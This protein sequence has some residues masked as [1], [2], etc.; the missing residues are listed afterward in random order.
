[1]ASRFFQIVAKSFPEILLPR[2]IRDQL[3]KMS[4]LSLHTATN[5]GMAQVEVIF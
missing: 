4:G 3:R 1:M 2:Q 5:A